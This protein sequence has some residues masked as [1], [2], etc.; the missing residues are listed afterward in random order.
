MVTDI[1]RESGRCNEQK[2]RYRNE[3]QRL[4]SFQCVLFHTYIEPKRGL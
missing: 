4:A 2:Y 1:G 3:R